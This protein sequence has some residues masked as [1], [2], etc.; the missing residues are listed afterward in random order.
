[1]KVVD[2]FIR[3][4]LE[5]TSSVK[6]K[7]KIK[8]SFR[9][10]LAFALLLI[11]LESILLLTHDEIGLLRPVTLGVLVAIVVGVLF[12]CQQSKWASL[13][14][15]FWGWLI[16]N[17][18]IFSIINPLPIDGSL[19]LILFCVYAFFAHGNKVGTILSILSVI[20]Y[21]I[22][23]FAYLPDN[24]DTYNR[25][26]VPK[27]QYYTVVSIVVMI[28][29]VNRQIILEFIK[30]RNK[31]EDDLK[32]KNSELIEQNKII[33]NQNKEKT[34]MMN[35]IHHRVKNNL[36]VINSLL[37]IQSRKLEDEKAQ[38]VFTEAQNRVVAMA[39]VHE[40][41][42]RN[43]NLGEIE[44]NSYIYNL[45]EEIIRNHK[46]YNSVNLEVDSEVEYID[47]KTM[48]PLGLILNELIINSLKHGFKKSSGNKIKIEF[49]HEDDRLFLCYYDNGIGFNPADVNQDESYG[50]ELIDALSTQIDASFKI[51][52]TEQGV[53]MC[54]VFEE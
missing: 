3:A 33:E 29:F 34:L 25:Y 1:M 52:K 35:E 32:A 5:K 24:M 43:E 28:F 10:W 19:W 41:I 16:V 42:Y 20:S 14:I 7:E 44:F 6:G 4:E 11:I 8:L 48:V 54:L 26:T 13:T 45:A 31:A 9:V 49:K 51:E 37:R 47:N 40:E 27:A 17:Y 39:L 12:R 18:A 30:A 2:W 46:S 15:T 22:F 53:H 23:V 36:Q 38:A 21:S 50:L